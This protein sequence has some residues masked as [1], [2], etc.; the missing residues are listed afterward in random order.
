MHPKVIL[1]DW[2]GTLANVYPITSAAINAARAFRGNPPLSEEDMQIQ[3]GWPLEKVFPD[4]IDQDQFKAHH[5]RISLETPAPPMAGAHELIEYLQTLRARG[6]YVGIISNKPHHLI[7][8][9]CT[10]FGWNNSFD[11]IIGSDDTPKRKPHPA[12]LESALTHYPAKGSLKKKQILYLGDT[13]TDIEF[14]KATQIPVIG[15]GNHITQSSQLCTKVLDLANAQQHIKQLM[16]AKQ[17]P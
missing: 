13:N 15:V 5:R 1:L 17:R 9:D 12:A 11:T 7:E 3:W 2:D 8:E 6:I 16:T 4:P 10:R 14:A